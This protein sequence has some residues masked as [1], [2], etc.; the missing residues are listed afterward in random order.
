MIYF[1]NVSRVVSVGSCPIF[2]STAVIKPVVRAWLNIGYSEAVIDRAFGG[3][4][5]ALLNRQAALPVEQVAKA[6]VCLA[7]QENEL[8]LGVHTGI[9]I[10]LTR[11]GVIS[12]LLMYG[13]TVGDV[14]NTMIGFVPLISQGV[15]FELQVQGDQ[16][17][18]YMDMHPLANISH[19]QEDSFITS[20][21]KLFYTVLPEYSVSIEF[22]HDAFGQALQYE[23]FL[24]SDV[25]FNA[26]RTQLRFASQHLEQTV[27]WSEKRLFSLSKRMAQTDLELKQ[28]DMPLPKLAKAIIQA[29]LNHGEPSQASVAK[30][31]NLGVR[32]FQLKLKEHNVCFRDLVVESRKDMAIELLE[33]RQYSSAEIA[34]MLGYSDTSTYY[35]AF[36]RWTGMSV[37]EFSERLN[38]PL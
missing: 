11:M 2:V 16:A 22:R 33:R 3:N 26:E 38:N 20:I 19:H 36:K 34:D 27:P 30:A 14:L 21:V 15:T 5:H 7:N 24:K 9:E 37:L 6:Y 29:K 32:N 35:R 18:L 23:R 25:K 1:M 4:Y 13:P 17:A 8:L 28:T 10:D 12:N 31:L